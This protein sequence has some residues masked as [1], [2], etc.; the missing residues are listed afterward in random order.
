M[1]AQTAQE[2]STECGAGEDAE[3]AAHSWARTMTALAAATPG[4]HWRLGD[5]GS[6]LA[7]TGAPVAGLNGVLNVAAHPRADGIG[8]LAAL[9]ARELTT[10][11]WSIQIRGEPTAGIVS[12]AERHGLTVRSQQPFM[13]RSFSDDEPVSLS[14]RASVKVRR[15]SGDDH[16]VFSAALAAGFAVPRHVFTEVASPVAMAAAG[17]T[18]YLAEDEGTAVATGTAAVFQ[19]CV[20]VFNISTLPLFRSRGYARAVIGR[21]LREGRAGGARAAYLHATEAGL[22]L[23][24]SVG[25]RTVEQWTTFSAP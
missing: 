11:P 21:I 12:V 3:R 7:F 17:M 18:A 19:D 10:V 9:A 6:V 14:G 23:Y 4:G 2:K 13:L 15:V 8:E 1:S 16:K 20:G 24:E 25:F 5:G 22:R